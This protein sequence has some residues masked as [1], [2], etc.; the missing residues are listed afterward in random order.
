[1]EGQEA[2]PNRNLNLINIGF[3]LSI[4]SGHD[5]PASYRLSCHPEQRLFRGMR[6]QNTQAADQVRLVELIYD[7]D[8]V[9]MGSSN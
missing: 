2:I 8:M 3:V 9:F 7:Q 6:A 4:P 5:Q 1:M